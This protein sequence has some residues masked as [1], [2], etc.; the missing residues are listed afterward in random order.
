MLQAMDA[1][2]RAAAGSPA[3]APVRGDPMFR[4]KQPWSLWT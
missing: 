2:K 4:L 3:E 1:I